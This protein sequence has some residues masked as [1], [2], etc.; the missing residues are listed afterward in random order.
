MVSIFLVAQDLGFAIQLVQSGYTEISSTRNLWLVLS[1]IETKTYFSFSVLVKKSHAHQGP[2]Q[3]TFKRPK[4]KSKTVL[5]FTQALC[6]L[7][8]VLEIPRQQERLFVYIV[9]TNSAFSPFKAAKAEMSAWLSDIEPQIEGTQ[10]IILKLCM[11]RPYVPSL[12]V[13]SFL[14]VTRKES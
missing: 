4:V 12:D 11:Y 3:C 1:I 2:V 6:F 10:R 7:S 14:K 13:K 9:G 8:F 5:V